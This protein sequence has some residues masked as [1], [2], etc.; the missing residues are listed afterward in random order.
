M[1][2]SDGALMG[3]AQRSLGFPETVRRGV[4]AMFA[5]GVGGVSDEGCAFR[6]KEKAATV[7]P[8]SHHRREERGVM[9][10]LKN[11]KAKRGRVRPGVR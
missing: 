2:G 7:R 8:E 3:P 11:G 5:G 1:S 6:F 4:V 10:V 9:R